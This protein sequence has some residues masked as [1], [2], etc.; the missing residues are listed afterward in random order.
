VGKAGNI[1]ITTGSLDV[2]K[3]AQLAA[4]T[5]G[6]GD[7]G[8]VTINDHD[9]VSFDRGYAFSTVK[10]SGMGNAGNIDITTGSLSVTNGA[11]LQ[12]L[13]RGRGNAGSVRINAH[14]R[15][16]FDGADIYGYLSAAYSTVEGTA[17]GHGG[18]IDIK[19][20]SLSVTNGAIL[21]ASTAGQG[22]GGEIT[23]NA[24]T[25]ETVNGGQVLI[26]F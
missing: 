18:G 1:N 15:V 5:A 2:T 14:D 9:T 8:N 6:R 4:Y 24:N 13:T 7:A 20:D 19:A 22:N 26:P 16:S 11:Q 12:S 10:A 17:V 21:T 3:G 25:L 23:L